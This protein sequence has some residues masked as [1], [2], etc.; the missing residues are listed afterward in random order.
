MSKHLSAVIVS[1]ALGASTMALAQ[2][3]QQPGQPR[4][5][6]TAPTEKTAP[7]SVTPPPSGAAT[8]TQWY[9][10]QGTEVRASKLIGTSVKNAA[11]ERIGDINEVI[12]GSDGKVAA[13]VIGVGGFLGIGEREVAVRYDALQLSHG[14]D[15]S[16]SATMAATKES[17]KTAPEWSWRT[18]DKSGVTGAGSKP[19]R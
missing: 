4:T 5:P 12:I 6:S 8:E 17:L 16:T 1:L 9:R 7:P 15:R 3:T 19:T 18:E 2:T 13:V 11:G 10:S 14:S